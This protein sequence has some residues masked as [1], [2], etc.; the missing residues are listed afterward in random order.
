MFGPIRSPVDDFFAQYHPFELDRT[1]S[2]SDEFQRL[3]DVHKMGKSTVLVDIEDKVDKTLRHAF[4]LAMSNE[5][6]LMYGSKDNDTARW[7]R[8]YEDLDIDSLPS[9]NAHAC[10]EVSHAYPPTGRHNQ[11][12]E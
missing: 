8:I 5:L 2:L 12:L 4:R 11:T 6:C 9:N 7:R 1:K 3:L 10:H